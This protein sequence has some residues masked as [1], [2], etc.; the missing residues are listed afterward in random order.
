[1]NVVKL[2]SKCPRLFTVIDFELHIWGNP[3]SISYIRSLWHFPSRDIP[4][5]LCR[6]QV[7]SNNLRCRIIISYSDISPRQAHR[8]RKLLPISIAHIPVPVP[9]SRILPGVF[10]IGARCSLLSISIRN[11][12]CVK[13]SRSSSCCVKVKE[14]FAKEASITYFVIRHNI[15]YIEAISTLLILRDG[16]LCIHIHLC[17]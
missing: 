9:T 2:L 6:A 7:R 10:P 1:M 15:S 16:D 3:E 14:A 4:R 5:R 13:S 12:W 8:D 11:F 17:S